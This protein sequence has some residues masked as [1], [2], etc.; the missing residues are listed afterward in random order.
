MVSKYKADMATFMRIGD[1]RHIPRVENLTPEVASAIQR[2]GRGVVVEEENE[3]TETGV[4]AESAPLNE[5]A[6]TDCATD[7]AGEVTDDAIEIANDAIGAE[8]ELG[9]NVGVSGLTLYEVARVAIELSM[10]EAAEDWT[11]AMAVWMLWFDQVCYLV[12][13]S[14]S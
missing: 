1:H 13:S 8:S 10:E 7:D 11:K 9:E 14:A 6:M 3:N 12:F 2:I 4:Q 5:E